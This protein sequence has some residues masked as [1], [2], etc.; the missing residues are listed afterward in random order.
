MT[1]LLAI[2]VVTVLVVNLATYYVSRLVAGKSWDDV[3]HFISSFRLA[4]Q[5]LD[6]VDDDYDF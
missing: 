1:E 5:G 4:A 2:F 6:I 3:V